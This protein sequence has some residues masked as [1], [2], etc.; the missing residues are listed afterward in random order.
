VAWKKIPCNS[1]ARTFVLSKDCVIIAIFASIVALLCTFIVV[2][3][4]TNVFREGDVIEWNQ[5]ETY[6]TT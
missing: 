1:V 5:Q 4:A 3:K 2:P 6:S